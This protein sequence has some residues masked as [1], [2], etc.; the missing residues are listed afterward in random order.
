M[1]RSKKLLA[2]GGQEYFSEKLPVNTGQHNTGEDSHIPETLPA[3]R[4]PIPGKS[5]SRTR[6]LRAAALRDLG[7]FRRSPCSTVLLLT[8][9]RRSVFF[10]L[11][12]RRNR[13]G[14]AE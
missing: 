6:L 1:H 4:E 12:L 7:G 10:L 3:P 14:Q 8:I 11:T 9:S 2:S 13:D 5:S